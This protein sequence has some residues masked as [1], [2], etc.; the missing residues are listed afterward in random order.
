MPS[1]HLL[2]TGDFDQSLFPPFHPERRQPA[3]VPCAGIK[4]D[5]V[6]AEF[7]RTYWRVTMHDQFGMQ[8]IECVELPPDPD[9]IV[10]RLSLQGDARA[11]AR[12]AEEEITERN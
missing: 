11:N 1:S 4:V 10:R 3:A 8:L 6:L 2:S 9:E 12:V 7:R 5:A